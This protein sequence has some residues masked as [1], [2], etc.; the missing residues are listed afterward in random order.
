[1]I[2]MA[3]K[4]T[5]AQARKRLSEASDKIMKVWLHVSRDLNVGMSARDR[6]DLLNAYNACVKARKK[7]E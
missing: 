1:V 2:A 3:K 6:A 4:L 7:L 5:K